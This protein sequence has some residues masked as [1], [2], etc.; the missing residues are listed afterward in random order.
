MEI[1][2]KV[3]IVTGGAVRVGRAISLGL[4]AAGCDLLVHYGSSEEAAREVQRCASTLGVRVALHRADLRDPEA[5]LGVPAAAREAFGRADLLVHNAALF[6]EGDLLGTSLDSWDRQ[7]AVNLRAPFLISSEF[8]RALG[9]E[10]RGRIVHIVDAR[11]FRPGA[12]HFAYR[13]T[14]AAL[15]AMTQGLALDL[16]PRISVNAVALGAILA[17]PGEDRGYLERLAEER[18]PLREAG[19][20]EQVARAV[21]HL[22]RSEF[23]TGAT[24]TLDGGQFL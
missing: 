12:D 13:L 1:E 19:E 8:A 3:A 17:P 10:R 20:P 5:A 4:A 14:K 15:H 24:L 7:F 9:E 18:I 16:A 11:I 2:G 6:E 23:T 21:L 22:L